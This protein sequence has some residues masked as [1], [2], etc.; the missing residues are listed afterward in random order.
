MP[1]TGDL[2][3][4]DKQYDIAASTACGALDYMVVDTTAAAQSCIELLRQQQLGV[5]TFLILEKQAHLQAASQERV[6]PPEG[7]RRPKPEYRCTCNGGRQACSV[8]LLM[9]SHQGH[10]GNANG[11][12]TVESKQRHP[13]SWG[14][15]LVL[16]L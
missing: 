14:T 9:P 13:L 12:M 15:S 8:S 6:Q 7:E 3:A 4:I 11:S 1:V 10:A 2:G 5:A 16:V